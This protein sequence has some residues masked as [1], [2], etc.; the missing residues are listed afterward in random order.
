M[1][2]HVTIIEPNTLHFSWKLT[3]FPLRWVQ[4]C[5]GTSTRCPNVV[6]RTVEAAF[7]LKYDAVQ[8]VL[9]FCC[10]ER[11]GATVCGRERGCL[12]AAAAHTHG[13]ARGRR[14]GALDRALSHLSLSLLSRHHGVFTGESVQHAGGTAD[15]WDVFFF[16]III[17]D[18]INK[19][20]ATFAADASLSSSFL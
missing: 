4:R 19:H 20:G 9:H 1:L 14:R 6:T 11:S 3:L 16:I 15:R 5:H 17:T 10:A 2:Q 8:L 13:S 12:A 7:P 18:M